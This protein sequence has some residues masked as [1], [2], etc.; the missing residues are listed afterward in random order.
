MS[1]RVN[2]IIVAIPA[3]PIRLETGH[4]IRVLILQRCAMSI[5]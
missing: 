4:E 3:C 1:L 5:R 2:H